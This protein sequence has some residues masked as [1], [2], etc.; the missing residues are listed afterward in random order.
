MV[1]LQLYDS[2]PEVWNFADEVG[3][4][5]WGPV[6]N[7]DSANRQKKSSFVPAIDVSMDQE[8]MKIHAELPGLKPEDLNIKV[9]EGVLTI[10]GEKKAETEKKTEG[11]YRLERSY[12][13][14]TRAFTLPPTVDS[15]RIQA[16]M[17][18]GVLELT[19]PKKPEAKEKQV[20]IQVH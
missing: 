2:F 5:F 16:S 15:E 8:S 3:Q 17:K 18:D 10:S 7:A 12:G 1:N 14:F 11:Y 6:K 19:I 9:L 20:Q 4:L 13:S